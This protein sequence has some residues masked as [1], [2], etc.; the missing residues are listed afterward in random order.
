MNTIHTKDK[1]Q[2]GKRPA[3]DLKGKG[4]VKS[5]WERSLHVSSLWFCVMLPFSL[6]WDSSGAFRGKYKSGSSSLPRTSVLPRSD[7]EWAHEWRLERAVFVCDNEGERKS[8][9]G[10][11]KGGGGRG[12]CVCFW[13][14][15]LRRR[16]FKEATWSHS[17]EEGICTE[18]ATVGGNGGRQHH[19]CPTAIV[20]H[21]SKKCNCLNWAG[22]SH[23]LVCLMFAFPVRCVGTSWLNKG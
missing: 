23:F 8:K 11:S 7:H 18:A 5:T 3:C 9:E 6:R 2:G 14:T 12:W 22:F 13:M 17:K 1:H 21:R 4:L 19:F 16:L 10:Q 20:I 15:N